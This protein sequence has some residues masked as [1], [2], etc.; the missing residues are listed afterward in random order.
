MLSFAVGSDTS[1]AMWNEVVSAG[2]A[3]ARLRATKGAV[4]FSFADASQVEYWAERV[5]CSGQTGRKLPGSELGSRFGLPDA[6]CLVDWRSGAGPGAVKARQAAYLKLLRVVAVS[7]GFPPVKSPVRAEGVVPVCMTGGIGAAEVAT[8]DIAGDGDAN[9][10]NDADHAAADSA[11]EVQAAQCDHPVVSFLAAVVGGRPQE[12]RGALQCVMQQYASRLLPPRTSAAKGSPSD[13]KRLANEL[14]K[15][16]DSLRTL[17][18]VLGGNGGSE[19]GGSGGGG[20]VAAGG[21]AG[22]G[23][24]LVVVL[25]QQQAQDAVDA[26]V[27]HWH[28]ATALLEQLSPGMLPFALPADCSQLATALKALVALATSDFERFVAAASKQS[29]FDPKM[30]SGVLSLLQVHLGRGRGKGNSGAGG[31]GETAL[32]MQGLFKEFAGKDENM[33]FA[34]FRLFCKHMKLN[35]TDAR[36]H[37]LFVI[38]DC[39]GTGH[40]DRFEFDTAVDI[41][42][43]D[44][45]ASAMEKVGAGTVKMALGFIAALL[46]LGSL[47]V[48]LLLGVAAF[49]TG[50]SFGAS[51]NSILPM[52]TA[53]GLGGEKKK[54]AG[55]TERQVMA[56]IDSSV[57]ADDHEHDHDS[58]PRIRVLT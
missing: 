7:I 13:S 49:T 36:Y 19:G 24:A 4:S 2:H 16:L 56:G 37:E 39:N 30:A 9:A 40:I 34:E 22:G 3:F 12:V 41:V 15:V 44:A 18:A 53:G 52:L 58:A 47:L 20:G 46:Y 32:T 21:G 55:D 31:S 6:L 38:A 23:A 1:F 29:K 5:Y 50:G 54:D 25:P 8:D 11:V 27:L 17:A 10:A 51:I 57:G 35:C 33:E 28:R 43:E 45:E 26:L 48:F 42:K 14:F